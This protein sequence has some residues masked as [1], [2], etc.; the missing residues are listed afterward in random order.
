MSTLTT[1]LGEPLVRVEGREKVTGAARYAAERAPAGCLHAWPVPATVAKGRVTAVHRDAALAEPGVV[2]VLAHDNAPRL[3]DAGDA[4]LAVLQSP[5]VAHRGQYVAVVVAETFEA[6]RAGAAA[7]RLEYA[8][9]PHDVLLRPGH[10]ATYTPGTVNGGYPATR[11]RG[12]CEAALASA[13]VRVDAVYRTPALHNHPMEPHASTAVWDGGLLTVHD[14]NQGSTLVRHVLAGLFGIAPGDVTVVTEHVG[15]AFGSKGTPR[16]HLVLA[17]MA[18]R[19][20]GRPV[21]LAVPRPQMAAV[22]GHRPPI[23][24]RLRIGAGH[25]GRITAIEHTVL[26]CTS[27]LKEFVEQAA[28]PTRAMYAAPNSRTTHRV[29]RL[30]VPTPS[31]MRA[32]GECPGMFALES[33][34]DELAAAC[35]LDPIELRVRNEPTTEPDTGRPFT[36]RHLVE[37]L[38]EGA[39]RFG[40]AERDPR[41]GL[42][43][44]GR[45]LLGSGVAASGYPGYIQPCRAEATALPPDGTAPHGGYRVRV[46]ATDLGTGA[47]TVLT[48]VAAHALRVPVDRVRVEIGRSDLPAAPVAGGSTGTAS[49]GWAVDKACCDLRRRLDGRTGP[50]PAD[51][52]TAAADTEEDVAAT[53]AHAR[54]AFGAQFAEVEVDVDTGETRV[55]RLLGVFAAGRILN[56]RT[57][58]SQLIG[59]MTMGLS[60]AL[61]EGSTMDPAFGDHTE[62]DLALYHV[63]TCADVRDIEAHWIEEDDPRVN[64]LGVKGIGEI[65]IVGTAAAVAN[66]VH[67]ATGVRVRDLPVRPGTLLQ[68]MPRTRPE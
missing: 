12:D 61:L 47:R 29:V 20:T 14:S 59:G 9:E 16:P 8:R 11:E 19:E 64:P 38:R 54:R 57:A 48:Q 31:W 30:D 21:K 53:G 33:A 49:W 1:P 24:Q 37:C 41:P 52:L 2:A 58:R 7:L 4:T 66:A 13:P 28:T 36:S 50:L 68:A 42:R 65:G 22:V 63:A 60:M 56:A 55:R 32:P 45:Y 25:D 23:E 10:P 51:G 44:R 67:H 43:R 18:A 27:T 3:G 35:R 34:M 62:R 39:R 17:V 40:W 15:G 46:N 26:T 5:R 6:A